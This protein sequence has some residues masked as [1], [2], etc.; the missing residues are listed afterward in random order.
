MEKKASSRTVIY[1]MI[2]TLFA[3]FFGLL[4]EVLMARYYGASMY[5]DA[6]IIA[7]NVP[8]VLFDTLGQALLTCFIPM[9]TKIKCE[10]DKSRADI[11]TL[12]LLVYLILICI[13]LTIV[14]ETLTKQI[15]LIF[16]S[17]FKGNILNITIE[18][19]RILFPSLFA[20]TILNLYTGYLQIYQKF[21]ITAIVPMIGN[22]V[23]IITL[24]ISN[25]IGNIYFFVWGSLFGLFF[26]VLFLLPSVKKIGLFRYNNFSLKKDKYVLQLIPLLLPVFIGS[27]LNEINSIIDRTMVSN[28]E[29]GSVST[30]NY[31][32]KIISLAITVIAMP[33]INVMYTRFSTFSA[34]QNGKRFKASVHQCLNLIL[35]I[36]IPVCLI[37][38]NFRDFIIKVLFERG[39]FNTFISAKTSDALAFY[40]IGLVCMCIQQ[41]FIRVFYS[42]QNTYIPMINGVISTVLNII[43]DFIMI[44]I[45]NFKGAALATSVTAIISSFILLYF[46]WKENFVSI[47]IVKKI[48]IK[49][50]LSGIIFG[51]I[52]NILVFM[53]LNN[54]MIISMKTIIIILLIVTFSMIAYL[55]IQILLKNKDLID[56]VRKKLNDFG[57]TV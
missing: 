8:T 23:I 51:I 33:I 15:V 7:N 32:Y 50:I 55:L 36:M 24:I 19:T 35:T 28:L 14:G 57:F 2:I 5:T 45:F 49:N 48:C 26:Q 3:R 17:G 44:K 30:L 34:Q 38:F 25:I 47:K 20:M 46:L 29:T 43:L 21:E 52:L 6:Y 4:R 22:I 31:A 39:N 1:V 37:I 11:F 40:T 53:F 54:N 16:A 27:A 12:R 18:F 10:N 42:K 9:Y 41:V 13:L 56:F